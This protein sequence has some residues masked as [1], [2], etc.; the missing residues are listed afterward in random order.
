V[1]QVSDGGLGLALQRAQKAA[2]EAGG[3]EIGVEQ[4]RAVDQRDPGIQFAGQ[5]G[6]RMRAA[7]QGHRIGA[8]QLNDAPREADALDAVP[9]QLLADPA[10][11]LIVVALA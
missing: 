6:Q 8:A 7:S 5:M 2:Q 1:S 4:Q 11:A 10:L 3:G 9:A